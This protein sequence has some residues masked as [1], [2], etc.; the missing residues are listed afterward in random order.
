[1]QYWTNG[2]RYRKSVFLRLLKKFSSTIFI[3]IFTVN[4]FNKPYYLN[5]EIMFYDKKK[6]FDNKNSLQMMILYLNININVSFIK[7]K[8]IKFHFLI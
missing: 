2:V 1:M 5:Y 6:T 3:Y 8:N 4:C 7:A